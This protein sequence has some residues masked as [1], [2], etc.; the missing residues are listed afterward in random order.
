VPEPV[1]PVPVPVLPVPVVLEPGAADSL[2][3]VPLVPDFEEPDV[4]DFE[5]LVLVDDFAAFFAWCFEDVFEPVP[6]SVPVAA[7]SDEPEDPDADDLDDFADFL[8]LAWCFF[9]AVPVVL[10]VSEPIEPLPGV[11]V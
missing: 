4:L 6:V 5:P 11:A 2:P 8:C 7:A 10:D 1:V 9:E 3:V